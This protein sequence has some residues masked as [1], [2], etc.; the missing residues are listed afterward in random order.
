MRETRRG[1]RIDKRSDGCN[2]DGLIALL[3]EWNTARRR[4]SYSG[5]RAGEGLK[6]LTVR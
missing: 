4:R 1:A 5:F 3:M 6:P 2:N